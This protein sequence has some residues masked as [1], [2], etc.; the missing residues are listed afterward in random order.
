MGIRIGPLELSCP[1]I[2]GS[3][4]AGNGEFVPE[5]FDVRRLGA[6][7]TKGLTIEPRGGHPPPRL[8]GVPGGMVNAIGLQNVGVERFVREKWPLLKGWGIPIIA[9][10]YGFSLDEAAKLAECLEAAEGLSGLEVNLSCPNVH[11]G[12]REVGDDPDAA[13]RWIEAVRRKTR[14]CVIAKL[15]PSG[16][17]PVEVARA[18]E[19]A[20]ADAICVGNTLRVFPVHPVTGGPLL[21]NG[22]GGFSGPALKP[23]VLGQIRFLR[24]EVKCAIVACGGVRRPADVRDYLAAGAAAVEV[25]TLHLFNPRAVAKLAPA[26]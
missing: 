1:V 26:S 19:R 22:F 2:L 17:R 11:G 16:S 20:G 14:R 24:E 6:F 23:L 18:V 7:V 13:S 9:N 10:L 25:A 3:G 5:F 21:S 15:P 12:G 4:V 8:A